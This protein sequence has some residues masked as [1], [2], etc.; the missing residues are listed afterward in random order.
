MT[1]FSNKFVSKPMGWSQIVTLTLA[2]WVSSSLLLDLVI[3]PTLYLSGMMAESDF[4]IAGYDLFW[5]FNRLE[6]VC[7]ALVATGLLVQ[8]QRKQAAHR[9]YGK[10]WLACL[11]FAIVLAYTYGL[12]PQM[13]AL[14]L[15]LDLYKATVEV[16]GMM[17]SLHLGYWVLEVFKLLAGCM[18]LMQSGLRQSAE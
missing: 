2:F 1:V 3:M 17:N 14:G 9:A 5:V 8:Q 15:Q 11:M 6:L 12:T 7:A 4:A 18:L 10:F 13:S 16:P